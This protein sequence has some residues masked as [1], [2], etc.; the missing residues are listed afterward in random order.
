M[1][2][3]LRRCARTKS[4]T[5]ST[6][7]TQA[8]VTS[9]ELVRDVGL[10]YRDQAVRQAAYVLGSSAALGN[11]VK[12]VGDLSTGLLDF[13]IEPAQGFVLGPLQFASG[14]SKGTASLVRNFAQGLSASA[15]AVGDSLGTGV[16]AL[17]MDRSYVRARRQ[18]A[19]DRPSNVATGFALGV[20]DL[21]GGLYRGVTGVFSQPVRGAQIDGLRGFVRGVGVGVLGVVVKPAVGVVDLAT[22]T[23]EGLRNMS[24]SNVGRRVRVPRAFDDSGAVTALAALVEATP[25]AASAGASSS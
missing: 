5:H 21:S 10:H 2:D 7:L 11:P 23:S 1:C 9:A 18:R 16:A 20:R 25:N 22:R 12:F 15:F 6:A 24:D 17:S 8:L 19:L 14:V 3:A 13:I 4:T